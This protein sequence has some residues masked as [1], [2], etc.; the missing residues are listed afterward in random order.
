MHLRSC[1]IELPEEVF[2]PNVRRRV[3]QGCSQ[4]YRSENVV[5]RNAPG[6]R[7][8]HVTLSQNMSFLHVD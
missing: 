3:N 6:T 1:N 8:P 5:L 4:S 2:R 7:L